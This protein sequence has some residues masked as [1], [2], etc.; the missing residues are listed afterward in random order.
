M[1]TYDLKYPGAAIDDILDTAYDLQ[2]AGYIFRGLASEYSN[3]PTERSWV[4]AGEGETGHGFASPVPKGYIGVCVFNGTSWTGKLLKC[5]SIDSTP[6]NGSTNAVSSGGAY[7]SIS[8]LA[9]TV[10]EALDNLTF[11]DTTPSAFLGEYITEKV[12][13]TDGGLERILTYFTILSATASKAGL[14]S[15]A[16]KAK[17]DALWSSGYQ[18]AGIATPSTTPV[19]TTSKIFYIAT[20]A[21]TYFNAV[22]ITQGIN[23]LS[24]NGI[25]WSAVQV[26]GID[27]EPTAGSSN[28][29]KSGGIA[30]S[31]K[32]YSRG[33]Y[34]VNNTVISYNESQITIYSSNDY[35]ILV[36]VVPEYANMVKIVN[37][38]YVRLYQ[39]SDN[40][41]EGL[42]ADNYLG[43]LQFTEDTWIA[44]EDGAKLI[45][46]VLQK[47]EYPNGYSEITFEF[48]KQSLDNNNFGMFEFN[49]GTTFY[50]SGNEIVINA[51]VVVESDKNV[52]GYIK[53]AYSTWIR[54]YFPSSGYTI[55]DGMC[56]II[57]PN[58]YMIAQDKESLE[59]SIQNV[60]AN[61]DNLREL[62]ICEYG[63]LIGGYG[64]SGMLSSKINDIKNESIWGIVFPRG[65]SYK[66]DGND[67]VIS[68]PVSNSG[69]RKCIGWIKKPGAVWVDIIIPQE[70][71]A[72]IE[73]GIYKLTLQSS[74]TFVIGDDNVAAVANGAFNTDKKVLFYNYL[75]YLHFGWGVQSLHSYR[76][77]E[78]ENA[79]KN[80]P[81]AQGV[82]PSYYDEYIN[83]R[84]KK[85]YT[86]INDMGQG[87][88]FGFITDTHPMMRSNVYSGKIFRNLCGHLP[89]NK[90]LF[91]GDIGPSRNSSYGQS[92]TADDAIRM[93]QT[94]NYERLYSPLLGVANIYNARGNHDF[95]SSTKNSPSE[96]YDFVN[97]R[98]LSR[99]ATR[100]Y[101]LN[102]NCTEII[103]DGDRNDANY[104]YFDNK[105]Q[106]IR[107]IVMDTCDWTD[108]NTGYSSIRMYVS[109][110]HIEW[111]VEDALMTT[112]GDYKIIVMSHV[113]LAQCAYYYLDKKWDQPTIKRIKNIISAV[114]NKTSISVPMF[115][116][117][118]S[119]PSG[120]KTY[121]FSDFTPDVVL[122]LGGH[123][124]WDAQTCEDGAWY[125]T[126]S[127]DFFQN[128]HNR[129][130]VERQLFDIEL[131]NRVS[132]TTGEDL[133][134]VILVDITN[135]LIRLFRIG[136]GLDKIF[137]TQKISLQAGNTA[138]IT[139]SL[140][141]DIAWK[142]YDAVGQVNSTDDAD[143]FVF[144]QT[145]T[146]VD[147]S[148][149]VVTGLAAGGS[150]VVA[151][152][153]DDNT[154][155]FF[156]VVVE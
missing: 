47:S 145:V 76:I 87:D 34:I 108:Y 14:L 45:G 67:V 138:T 49:P 125:Y 12:S 126:S 121:N 57:L 116:N 120:S 146:S 83:E 131:P 156:N 88:V 6:T 31:A 53:Y 23:L 42:S 142:S 133:L 130:Y 89:I 10:N 148:T 136:V 51:A 135:H 46:C 74:C 144:K 38:D 8:Q 106:K 25:A 44:L 85:I 48:K 99:I 105:I 100:Q 96:G 81:D 124:H 123:L 55:A 112:P 29:I 32:W 92:A 27:D 54:V 150:I 28:L 52:L 50:K 4:L 147:E 3:T 20:E 15:A 16:D 22:T 154:M 114:N 68:L 82:L 110:A 103:S 41:A 11:T 155:E 115:G 5:V 1:A 91:G 79:V 65:A 143:D 61:D 98:T 64:T 71:E 63:T 18:F 9:D 13:T 90:V 111:F 21:G 78:I 107:Y 69:G 35:D 102:S 139:C 33:S 62:L 73:E 70:E 141:G 40:S 129:S 58:H 36:L 60:N 37:F 26:V 17:L 152:S 19:S 94:E 59:F 128:G 2:N 122:C 95:V 127:A 153:E 39:F 104:F 77:E 101:M 134:N 66:R 24:W 137:H 109:D 117:N 132:G 118:T 7:A 86:A 93:A 80:L 84:T 119:T 113:P 149:G 151:Y 56:S 75:G 72:N 43:N 97:S 140:S 30:E